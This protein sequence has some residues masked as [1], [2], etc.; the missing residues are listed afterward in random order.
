MDMT[1]VEHKRLS[2]AIKVFDFDFSLEAGSPYPK[3]AVL[4]VQPT[5][6]GLLNTVLFWFELHLAPGI[7]LTTG[8]PVAAA[9]LVLHL[10]CSKI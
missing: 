3:E 9:S 8:K 10:R 6:P 4:K 7:S 1:V 5:Q 2:A